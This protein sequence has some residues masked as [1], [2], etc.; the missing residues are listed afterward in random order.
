MEECVSALPV[1]AWKPS[2]AFDYPLA[3]FSLAPPL[4]PISLEAN[5]HKACIIQWES[6]IYVHSRGNL[7]STQKPSLI[8]LVGAPWAKTLLD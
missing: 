6:Q 8:Y 2:V 4:R 5:V 7:R 3:F 1:H